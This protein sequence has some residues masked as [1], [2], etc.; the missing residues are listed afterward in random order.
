M[1]LDAPCRH[2]PDSACFPK[3][4]D[5]EEMSILPYDSSGI[6]YN[7]TSASLTNNTSFY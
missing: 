1:L 3:V 5:E 7:F 2:V 6:F 4:A